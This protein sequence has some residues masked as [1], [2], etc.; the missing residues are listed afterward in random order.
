MYA[1]DDWRD[2]KVLEWW[3]RNSDATQACPL[4]GRPM[5][6]FK[7]Q[8]PAG[9]EKY[10][11][12]RCSDTWKIPMQQWTSLGWNDEG[13]EPTMPS[14]ASITQ[15]QLLSL[16]RVIAKKVLYIKRLIYLLF[17][18]PLESRRAYMNRG[19]DTSEEGIPSPVF[20]RRCEGI[21][22]S[23]FLFP[24][25]TGLRV[26]L[27]EDCRIPCTWQGQLK[28]QAGFVVSRSLTLLSDPLWTGGVIEATFWPKKIIKKGVTLDNTLL[29]RTHQ[30]L[31][32]CN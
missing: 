18:G 9:C 28:E 3:P 25:M 16:C 21:I 12:S 2:R 14:T 7:S 4:Q 20:N 24:T 5:T 29:S 23:L 26:V 11:T 8:A 15:T 10:G 31:E 32:S 30:I 27:G 22:T 17:A 19:L 1:D 6:W 13:I